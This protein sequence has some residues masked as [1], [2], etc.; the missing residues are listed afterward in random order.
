V[1]EERQMLSGNPLIVDTFDDGV[2]DNWNMEGKVS[3]ADGQLEM[4]SN[5]HVYS[6]DV[7]RATEENPLHLEMDMEITGYNE[8][9][10]IRVDTRT[11][12]N[13]DAPDKVMFQILSSVKKGQGRGELMAHDNGKGIGAGKAYMDIVKGQVYHVSIHD[14]GQTAS[15]TVEEKANPENKMELSREIT[16]GSNADLQRLSFFAYGGKVIIDNV[17]IGESPALAEGEP[18]VG[19]IQQIPDNQYMPLPVPEIEIPTV[20]SR[21]T[22]VIEGD[23]ADNWNMKGNVNIS[24]GQL[25]MGSGAHV[26]S[27]DI[28]PAENLHFETDITFPKSSKWMYW[29]FDVGT[30]D[31]LDSPN[32]IVIQA[33]YGENSDRFEVSP[34]KD[35]KGTGG[36]KV[37]T[38]FTP[39]IPYHVTVVYS[40]GVLE[41]SIEEKGNPENRYELRKET[42]ALSPAEMQRITMSVYSPDNSKRITVDNTTA[43]YP[44]TIVETV[45]PPV[46]E[47]IVGPIQTAPPVNQSETT[48]KLETLYAEL[49][50]IN[51]ILARADS[52]KD[53]GKGVTFNPHVYTRAKG[54]ATGDYFPVSYSGMPEGCS[55]LIADT[56]TVAFPSG[57]NE[58]VLNVMVPSVA[59]NNLKL[60]LLGPDG[61]ALGTVTEYVGNG[62]G[63]VGDPRGD[64]TFTYTTLTEPEITQASIRKDEIAAEIA[65]LI[66]A[67][68]ES[69]LNKESITYTPNIY[70]A[71]IEGPNILFAIES[72]ADKCWVQIEG[73]GSLSAIEV[74]HEGGTRLAMGCVVFNI[75]KQPGEYLLKQT[76]EGEGITASTIIIWDGINLRV[77]HPEEASWTPETTIQSAM[78]GGIG[79]IDKLSQDIAN[80]EASTELFMA[81]LG[82][83][84]G[85]ITSDEIKNISAS[86]LYQESSMY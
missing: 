39:D 2:G 77:K 11:T 33:F 71:A 21:T 49:D 85:S 52:E 81:Q 57:T 82:L 10:Y 68:E 55:V 80:A 29:R 34:I 64:E 63:I 84:F 7:I 42:D 38:K 43:G 24:D 16:A 20:L 51:G 27:K 14:N 28:M 8:Y 60:E 74:E 15:L 83:N 26:H 59:G 9:G 12:D 73:Q 40:G 17:E 3:V 6:K 54:S 62:R 53:L 44:A 79:E 46:E 66:A 69:P 70:V 61:T 50:D 18:I 5:S 75:T 58:G 30:T 67:A 4:N 72:P 19:P 37:K 41:A 65:A 13:L 36:E 47:P 25:V 78:F 86:N 45:N 23:F 1:F 32:Q 48:T 76:V 22:N 56:I 35:G 31:N